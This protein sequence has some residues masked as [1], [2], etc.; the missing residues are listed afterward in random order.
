LNFFIAQTL[1]A[2]E[3]RILLGKMRGQ[4]ICLK[5]FILFG[6]ITITLGVSIEKLL[7]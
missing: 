6:S 5:K 4:E 1:V 2:A 7:K 3:F